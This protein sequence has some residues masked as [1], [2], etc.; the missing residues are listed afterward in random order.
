MKLSDYKKTQLTKELIDKIV[1]DKIFDSGESCFYALVFGHA[2]LIKER[3]MK[4]VEMYKNGR[5]KKLVF[6]GGGY[7]DSNTSDSHIPES[8]QMRDLAIKNGISTKDIIVEDKSAN[9]FENIQFGIKLLDN[10]HLDK[11]MLITSEFH[12][13]R[14]NGI[15]KK[16]LPTSKTVLVKV[17]DGLHDRDNW[18]LNDNVWKNAGKNGSGKSLVEHEAKALIYGACNKILED[19]EV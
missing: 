15:V 1:F 6:L 8:Y 19:L 7:G 10:K 17:N 11:I 16:V 14:C 5:A 3:T 2:R 9:T 13:K 4:A 12:L 18:F